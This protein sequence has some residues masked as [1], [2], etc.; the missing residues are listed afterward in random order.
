MPPLVPTHKSTY[1]RTNVFIYTYC[2]QGR[3]NNIKKQIKGQVQKYNNY[4]QPTNLFDL[5]AV[6]YADDSITN[7]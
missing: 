4:I 3:V 7:K 6:V 1:V 5:H 2:I